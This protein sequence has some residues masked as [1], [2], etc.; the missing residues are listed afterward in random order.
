MESKFN[1][2]LFV[3]GLIISLCFLA[4]CGKS[5]S[6]NPINKVVD[7][8]GSTN[9]PGPSTCYAGANNDNSACVA[10]KTINAAKEGY[11]NPYTDPSF[12]ANG[13]KNQY[14]MPVQ[15]VNL[16]ISSL[17][18]KLA[19]NF[20]LV[21]LMSVE[22]ASYGI[23]SPAV[24]KIIQKLRD[25]AH[26]ALKINSGYRP[27]AWNEGVP[28]SAKWSRHQYG[29]AVDIASPSASL[30]QLVK[31]CKSLGATYVDKYVVHVHCDWRN[32]D[33][34]P[35]FYG[36]SNVIRTLS[37]GEEKMNIL[38]DL[39][40]TSEIQVIGTI[41][42]GNIV[43]LISTVT[44]K[45]D[46][47]ELYKRWVI[48]KPNGDQIDVEQAEVSLPLEKGTYQVEHYIGADIKLNKT[49]VVQ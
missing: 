9:I 24:L 12:M 30:D 14:R 3:L 28:G 23:F 27:P 1:Q 19:P 18:L 4:A 17:N 47:D 15:A 35:A 48:T 10:L 41:K 49:I 11:K 25:A 13:N 21:E 33:L 16:K 5:S 38:A 8:E 26:G 43:R 44:Y 7:G 29:D 39:T 20:K 45:E 34:E 2:K 46:D 31:L 40:D 42:A 37:E 6:E 22:K 36:A 32:H